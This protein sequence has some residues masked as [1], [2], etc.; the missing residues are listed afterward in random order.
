M[1]DSVMNIKTT[2][3]REIHALKARL[4]GFEAR[5][6]LYWQLNYM[7]LVLPLGK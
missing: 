6:G 4:V 5:A 7:A 3:L 1:S 2:S